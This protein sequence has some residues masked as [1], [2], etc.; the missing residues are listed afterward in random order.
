M[1]GEQHFVCVTKIKTKGGAPTST[2]R[3]PKSPHCCGSEVRRRRL[4]LASVL[5][6][7]APRLVTVAHEVPALPAL[8]C[9]GGGDINCGHFV[10]ASPHPARGIIGAYT[11]V[12][13][14]DGVRW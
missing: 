7:P 3:R 14:C 1:G 5:C 2:G 9:A 12:S 11:R 4:L 8:R 10:S 13:A 6:P